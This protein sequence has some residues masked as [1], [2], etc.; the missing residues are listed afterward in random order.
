[1]TVLRTALASDGVR[2]LLLGWLLAS[3]GIWAFTILIALYAYGE[4]G[5]TAVGVAVLVRMLPSGLAAPSVALLADRHSRRSVLVVSCALRA[6][7]LGLVS[8]AVAQDAP[9][10][11]VLVLAALFT[12]AGTAH[13]PAQAAL[14][15]QLATVPAQ[16][17]AA[18]AATSGIEYAGFLVGSLLAGVVANL[19]G[20]SAGMAV[21]AIPFLLAG[22][23]LARLPHD[24]RPA[25]L[26]QEEQVGATEEALEGFR[27]VWSDAD[28]RLLTAMYAANMFVQGVVDVLLVLAAIELL[29]MGEEGVGWLN[30]AWGVG[31][32]AGSFM[33][34]SL[35]GR[36]RLA[37][38]LTV[39]SLLA[40]L[41]LSV[42]GFWHLP[43]AAILLLVVLGVGYALT[44]V[45][46]LT[47][48]QRLAADDVLARVFGVQETLFVVMT[49][50]GSLL[51]AG[52]VAIMSLSAT[53][54][55]T[56]LALPVLAVVLW[57]RLEALEVGHAIPERAYALLR[58]LAMFAPLPIAT[59]ENLAV[60]SVTNDREP[61]E[62]II[63][64]G[65]HGDRFYVIDEGT[66]D[67]V[68]DGS[69]I[70]QRFAGDCLGEIALLRDTPRTATVIAATPLRL[71][72]LTRADFLAGA[73]S[74]PRSAFAAESLVDER[75]GV[76]G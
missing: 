67:I 2:R 19:V 64:Q 14:L 30:S 28:M 56:G 7:A 46:M 58:G 37:S 43:G 45:A 15:P 23:V 4:G 59:I 8:L 25:P 5:A 40:G 17:A 27:V 48:T 24:P 1:M 3:T 6:L 22:A 39:G 70:G 47:L 11:A 9:F 57:R 21:C 10:A 42:I 18:N 68:I 31:G 33:A 74:H 41:P 72:E 69:P 50:L 29:G 62:E 38:G 66:V 52:L 63:R 12:I 76:A 54:V 20:L 51:A 16:I 36:G 35:L 13:K 71:I 61:G 34:L 65:D 75:L 55:V 49:A 73:L 26:P 44:E 32:L 53:L 60:H